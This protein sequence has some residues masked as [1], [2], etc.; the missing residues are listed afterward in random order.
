MELTPPG[1]PAALTGPPPS[2]S[3]PLPSLCSAAHGP[4]DVQRGAALASGLEGESGYCLERG[5]RGSVGGG[6]GMP[7]ADRW[8]NRYIGP[9]TPMGSVLLPGAL[10]GHTCWAPPS[11]GKVGRGWGETG[12]GLE[13]TW[14]AGG[15]LLSLTKIKRGDLVNACVFL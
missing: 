5:E 9:R 12:E 10:Q 14:E 4:T 15:Q 13:G 11:K 2:P 6:T 7:T 3:A 1:L 8:A